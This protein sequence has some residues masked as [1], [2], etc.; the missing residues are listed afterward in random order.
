M[1]ALIGPLGSL[2]AIGAIRPGMNVGVERPSNEF[3]SMGGLRFAQSAPRALR[4][5][6]ID[7]STVQPQDIALLQALADGSVVGD[8]YMY[9]EGWARQNLLPPRYG[10]PSVKGASDLLVTTGSWGGG[11]S[12]L[13]PLFGTVPVYGVPMVGARATSEVGA[14]DPDLMAWSDWMPI[15][16]STAYVFTAHGRRAD[17]VAYSVN[18]SV[19]AELQ[20]DSAPGETPAVVTH[21]AKAQTAAID[22]RGLVA[23]TTTST[24]RRFRVRVRNGLD[25]IVSGLQVTEGTVSPGVY[26]P[27]EGPV[28]VVVEDGTGIIDRVWP[29]AVLLNRNFVIKEVG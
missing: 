29:E 19:L 27:G 4:S 21:Q 12:V 17:A 11:F 10:T 28:K 5:W 20:T 2:K 16:P 1:K 6:T 8:I 26:M 22:S 18:V 24:A 3:I 13:A 14:N 7:K 23:F 9:F 25:Q 15:L